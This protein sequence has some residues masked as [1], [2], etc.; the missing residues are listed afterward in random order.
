MGLTCKTMFFIVSQIR[1]SKFVMDLQKHPFF[2]WTLTLLSQEFHF[3][4]T[5]KKTFMFNFLLSH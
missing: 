2:Y 3:E 4:K 5:P 1:K